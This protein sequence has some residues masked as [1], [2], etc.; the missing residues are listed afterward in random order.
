MSLDFSHAQWITSCPS[1][2]I[3]VELLTF[4]PESLHESAVNDPSANGSGY[5]LADFVCLNGRRRG[6]KRRDGLGYSL[7]IYR[8]I[9]ETLEPSKADLGVYFHF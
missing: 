4:L 8:V 6:D 1:T 9:Q 7:A 2:M 5:R 3:H